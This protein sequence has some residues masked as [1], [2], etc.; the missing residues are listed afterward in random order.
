MISAYALVFGGFLLLGG[1]LADILGRRGVF[2]VGLVDLLGRI[3]SLRT[4]LERRVPDRRARSA[5]PGSRHDHALGAVDPD[6]HVHRGSRAEH[7]SRRLGRRR[8]R[9]GRSRR[10]PRRDPHRPP[11]VGVDLLRQRPRRHRRAGAGAGPAP[12]EQGRARAEPRHPRR[13]T[14]DVR[15][16]APRPR[17]HA[18]PAVG[19]ALGEDDRRVRRLA[20]PARCIRSLGAAAERAARSVLDLPAANADRSERGHVRHGHGDVLDVP[21]ADALHA[22]GAR[23]LGRSRPAS[24]TSRSRARR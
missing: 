20:R 23:V 6:D 16:R 18:G 24:P 3:A 13:G 4:G 1:R 8:R 9:R 15:A 17:G 7:R 11:L 14:R 19:V 10:A 5:G 21:D 2:M 12:R 22:A